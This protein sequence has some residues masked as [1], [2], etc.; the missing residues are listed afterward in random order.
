MIIG[1]GSDTL[2]MLNKINYPKKTPRC[3]AVYNKLFEMIKSGKFSEENRLPAEI[4]L[5]KEMSVSRSTLR[6]AL[7][8]L[9]EDG[10]IKSIQGKGSF[11][12]KERIKVE[13]GLEL[14]KNPIY[15]VVTQEI[16][17]VE[18]EFRIEP[19]NDYTTEIFGKQISI[20]IFADR[21]FKIDGEVVAYTISVIPAETVLA[22]KIDLNDKEKF[23]NY[24]NEEIYK[25]AK[26]SI[27]K[28][29]FSEIGNI[30]SVKYRLSKDNRCH[31]LSETLYGKDGA[32]IMYNKHYIPL[33]SG[34]LIIYRK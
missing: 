13:D 14:L 25:V 2:S 24:L 18:F 5:A 7:E 4:E 21:W 10:I 30:S 28:V 15:S 22:G 3:I 27:L 11:I 19:G 23:L 34:E 20:V 8:L 31:L 17:E 26:S 33:E 29:S 12:V 6:Q 32:P 1:K 9:Q 16:T